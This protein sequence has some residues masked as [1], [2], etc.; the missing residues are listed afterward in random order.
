MQRRPAVNREEW[1]MTC[2]LYHAACASAHAIAWL[3]TA[4]YPIRDGCCT[5]SS[6][7]GETIHLRYAPLDTFLDGQAFA[8]NGIVNQRVG[9]KTFP[10]RRASGKNNE[11][12]LLQSTGNLIE[13]MEAGRYA[14]DR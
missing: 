11:V 4:I 7:A 9:C 8:G 5:N 3:H 10:N 12:G 13:V 2:H 14:D 1:V 6:C